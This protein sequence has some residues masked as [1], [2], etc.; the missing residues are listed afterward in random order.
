MLITQ[1][2]GGVVINRE[3]KVLVVSQKGQSW[4]LPKGHVEDGEDMLAAAIR[5]IYE[6]SGID[7]LDTVKDLGMYE[8]YKLNKNNQD[9]VSELKQIY[10]FLFKTDQLELHPTDPENPEARWV[11]KE[12]ASSLL[13]HHR[14]REFLENV[15][16]TVSF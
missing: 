5:E 14:D 13:S 1:S 10:M 11:N 2:A 6:E 7:Q 4:S 15:L 3:G 8:R 12:E 9:D 16:R